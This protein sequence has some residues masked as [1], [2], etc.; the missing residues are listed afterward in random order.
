M[1]TSIGRLEWEMLDHCVATVSMCFGGQGVVTILV[2]CF[3][4]M[5][6][7]AQGQEYWGLLQ[8]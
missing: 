2:N 8:V 3:N 4:G 1:K 7:V 6:E 5:N